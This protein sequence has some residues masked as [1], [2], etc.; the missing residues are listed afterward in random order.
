MNKLNKLKKND[1]AFRLMSRYNLQL[2]TYYV[3]TLVD[4]DKITKS[5]VFV[6][7]MVD[8]EIYNIN[9]R[10]LR[11]KSQSSYGSATYTLYTLDEAK[12]RNEELVEQG[13]R[14]RG[15]KG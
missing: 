8:K 7:T 15:F 14:V 10:E 9:T 3:W 11:R 2:G 12:V 1:K 13:N 4:V 5:S 6:N